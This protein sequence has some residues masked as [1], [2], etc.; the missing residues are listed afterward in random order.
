[1]RANTD[2][3]QP[4]TCPDISLRAKHCLSVVR[5]NTRAFT[6]IY[7]NSAIYDGKWIASFHRSFSLVFITAD[8][9]FPSPDTALGPGVVTTE[10]HL[11]WVEVTPLLTGLCIVQ[12]L[13][14]MMNIS[15]ESH[16][17]G[18]WG[19]RALERF[20]KRT[21]TIR[22]QPFVIRSNSRVALVI[23]PAG[24]S[25]LGTRS[26]GKYGVL[27]NQHQFPSCLQNIVS[28]LISRRWLTSDGCKLGCKRC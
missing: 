2:L 5:Y 18:K 11:W 28:S 27:Q 3:A 6:T 16:F 13:V 14:Q 23:S 24:L 21:K 9:R 19:Q 15:T 7:F 17:V 12:L 25:Q 1:M 10:S 20:Q 4:G 22:V 26:K 8:L